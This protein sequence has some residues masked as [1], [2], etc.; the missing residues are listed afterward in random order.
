MVRECIHHQLQNERQ[1][2]E[3]GGKLQPGKGCA[4]EGTKRWEAKSAQKELRNAEYQLGNT[5][6]WIG[7]SGPEQKG[8]VG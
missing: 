5:W 6:L 2:I 7:L 4:E 8:V 3:A 1:D